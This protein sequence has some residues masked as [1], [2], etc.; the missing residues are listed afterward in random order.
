MQN[1]GPFGVCQEDVL[2]NLMEE[3]Y[4][5]QVLIKQKAQWRVFVAS[6]VR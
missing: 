5:S 6:I 4:N 1:F 2:E 3:N